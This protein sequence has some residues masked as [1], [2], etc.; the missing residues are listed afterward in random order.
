MIHPLLSLRR[1]YCSYL[2]FGAPLGTIRNWNTTT[3]L[4]T[5]LN[6]RGAR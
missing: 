1:E 5:L 4:L 2:G 3:K 6:E